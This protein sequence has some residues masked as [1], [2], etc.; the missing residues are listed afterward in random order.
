MLYAQL[1]NDNICDGY[2]NLSQVEDSSYLVPLPGGWDPD[3]LW[4]KYENGQWSAEKFEPAPPTFR[5]TPESRIADF[6]EQ[7][8]EIIFALVSNNLM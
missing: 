4:R 5:P 7:N 8:A 1:N 3:L 2:S 6:E